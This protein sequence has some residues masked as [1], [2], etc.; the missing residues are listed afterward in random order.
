MRNDLK[1]YIQMKKESWKQLP[2]FKKTGIAIIAFY[3][4]IEAVID[5]FK[6]LSVDWIARQ[7]GISESYLCRCYKDFYK[8][9]PHKHIVRRKIK[10]ARELL[11]QHPDLS[12]DEIAEKLDY[13]DGNYFIKVFKKEVEMTPH[14]FRLKYS[15][16][17]KRTRKG[18]VNTKY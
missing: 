15:K 5:D 16:R 9:S 2:Q 1:Q 4:I 6:F 14:Q 10:V 7:I 11:L 13:C 8:S 12:I 17:K 3:I 18:R